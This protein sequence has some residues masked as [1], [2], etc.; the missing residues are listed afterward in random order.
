MLHRLHTV[1]YGSRRAGSK[2]ANDSCEYHPLFFLDYI[3]IV[4]RPPL[5][6]ITRASNRF[7]DNVTVGLKDW[8]LPYAEKHH[9]KMHFTS[10]IARSEW[11]RRRRARLGIL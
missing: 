9:Y 11:P 4:G 8:H 10:S 6:A 1:D 7:F 5:K 3:C 2:A